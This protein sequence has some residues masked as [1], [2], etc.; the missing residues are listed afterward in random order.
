MEYKF[1]EIRDSGTFIPALAMR[2]K[3]DTPAQRY[4]L[5]RTGFEGHGI[6]VLMRLDD[7]LASSDPYAWPALTGRTRTMHIAHVWPG[8]RLRCG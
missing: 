4:L 1:V 2:M 8:R 6:V 3:A 7:Q 5:E